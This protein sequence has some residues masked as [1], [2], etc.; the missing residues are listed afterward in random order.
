MTED[1]ARRA[2]TDYCAQ[3]GREVQ[4]ISTEH[5]K[6]GSWLFVEVDEPSASVKRGQV[7]V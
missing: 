3:K 2:Y 7:S 6:G 5:M 1:Q 4:A